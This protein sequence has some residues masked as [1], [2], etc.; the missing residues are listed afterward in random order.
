MWWEVVKRKKPSVKV[1]S[2]GRKEISREMEE[3]I[4]TVVDESENTRL[5]NRA[6]SNKQEM[7]LKRLMEEENSKRHPSEQLDEEYYKEGRAS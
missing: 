2:S 4:D 7:R 6:K 1:G 5:Q 3:D